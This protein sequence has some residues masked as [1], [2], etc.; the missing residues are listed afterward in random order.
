MFFLRILLLLFI[1]M[2]LYA[3]SISL[4]QNE[5]DFLKTHKIKC[6]I[7]N[8]WTPFYF[9]IDNKYHGIAIDFWKIISKKYNISYDCQNTDEFRTVING[10]K[11]KT[12]D[13]TLSTAA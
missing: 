2:N 6:I 5:K 10:I 13:I 3:K 1:C 11:N 8:N 7:T 4:T 9:K 12:F